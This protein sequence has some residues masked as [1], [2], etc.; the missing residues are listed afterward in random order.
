M[1]SRLYGVLFGG[2]PVSVVTHRVQHV[3]TFEA[4][5]AGVDIRSDIS[6]GVSYVQSGTR[7]IGKH[8][9]HIEFGFLTVFR[10]PIGVVIFPILLPFLLDFSEI[11]VHRYFFLRVLYAIY[12]LQK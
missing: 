3:E 12:A 9:Q 11:V 10:N 2:Q 4:F 6:E 1:L 5:E 7:R 8:I